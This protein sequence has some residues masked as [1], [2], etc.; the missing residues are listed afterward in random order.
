MFAA[1][2]MRSASSSLRCL[3]ARFP[4]TCARRACPKPLPQALPREL[5]TIVFKALEKA[6]A[7]R[8]QSV[9]ALADDVHRYLSDQ[10]ILA[11]PPSAIYQLRKL[12]TRHKL[13]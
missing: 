9:A 11:Q 4:T 1:M 3:P 13:G 5:N 7:L 10:P 12:V 2:S 8:Y 6:P